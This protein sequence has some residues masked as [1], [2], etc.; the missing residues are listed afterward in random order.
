M[1]FDEWFESVG[2]ANERELAWEAWQAALKYAA[3]Q[4][5]PVCDRYTQ[6]MDSD[7]CF[8]CGHGLFKH[9]PEAFK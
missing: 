7:H 8:N 2:Y 3:P 4:I 1:T 5:A 6:T 9:H